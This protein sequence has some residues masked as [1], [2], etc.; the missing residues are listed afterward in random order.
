MN[1]SVEATKRYVVARTFLGSWVLHTH[2]HLYNIIICISTSLFFSLVFQVD[3]FPWPGVVAQV[4]SV[5]T[6]G[7][8]VVSEEATFEELLAMPQPNAGTALVLADEVTSV[9]V[10]LIPS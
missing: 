9:L 10:S 8:E 2:I 5:A 1:I 4:Q 6:K 3:Q 7:G